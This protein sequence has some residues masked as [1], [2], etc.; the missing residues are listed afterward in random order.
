MRF[1]WIVIV[2]SICTMVF[3]I[4]LLLS[5]EFYEVH[6]YAFRLSHT[7]GRYGTYWSN[8]NMLKVMFNT[9]GSENF[10]NFW[11]ANYGEDIASNTT[12]GPESTPESYMPDF[13]YGAGSVCSLKVNT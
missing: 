12:T 2:Q 9:S 6:F 8:S 5:R 4:Q 3:L 7:T 10:S 13:Y 11:N 1:L